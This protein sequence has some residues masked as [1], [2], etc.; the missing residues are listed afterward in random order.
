VLVQAQTSVLDIDTDSD[1]LSDTQEIN[2]YFTDPKNSDTDSDGFSDGEEI[3]NKYSPLFGEKKRLI[4]V[5]SDK[6]Y[7]ND[8]WEIILGTGLMTPDSDYDKFLDGTEVAAGYD[9]LDSQPNKL[10]KLI[11]VD[12]ATQKLE[13]KFGD[14]ILDSF[15]IS[16]G[17]RKTP[18]PKGNFMVLSKIPVKRYTGSNYDYKNTKWNLSF[19]PSYYI[20]GAYWHNKFGQPMS[21]GCVNV[22]YENM[23]AL[24]WWAQLGTPILIE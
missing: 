6:D 11:K 18:T 5:D 14:K 1:G 13:Y 7:L 23:E 19:K 22:A 17:L 10:A 12:L 3:K 16:S 15:S 9:P 24:Y 4:Q 2:V 20:H 21:H 8:A